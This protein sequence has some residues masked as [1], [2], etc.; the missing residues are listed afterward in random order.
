MRSQCR[1]G[2]QQIGQVSRMLP[3]LLDNVLTCRLENNPVHFHGTHQI[4]GSTILY[5]L[6]V[7]TCHLEA[8]SQQN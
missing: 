6:Q 7:S 4:P 3:R 5:Q 2:I 8:I 1:Q